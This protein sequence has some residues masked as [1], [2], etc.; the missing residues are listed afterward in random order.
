MKTSRGERIHIGIFGKTNSGKSSLLN[1]ITGQDMAVVS[2]EKGTTT[3]PVYKT[4]ELLPAG[5]VVFIDTAG[6]DDCGTVGDL[7]TEKTR[8]IL[9][10]V[11]F[12]LLVTD[13]QNGL[14]R[15]DEE[16][17]SALKSA[18]LP[19]L[20][21]YNKADI[22]SAP[23]KENGIYVS[24]KTGE[25]IHALKEKIAVTA[26]AE[27][28]TPL[29]ADLINAGDT[30]ILVIPIDKAAP[31][32][33]IILPQ[34]QVLREVLD[35]G[36]IGISTRETEL[37]KTLAALREPPALVITD[38]QA[39]KEVAAILPESIPL[40]SFSIL[41]SRRKGALKSAISG[42]YAL[43]KICDGD[44]I[45]ISEACSHHRQCDDIATVKLPRLI[46]AHTNAKPVYEF[47]SGGEFPND[48]QKYKLIIHC[49]AC[50]INRREMQFR[51]NEAEASKIPITNFGI[52]IGYMTG[53]LARNLETLSL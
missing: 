20:V 33:R 26:K 41:M 1:A 49:G 4:M 9:R 47:T 2:A 25:N 8:E 39:F 38:S 18:D 30:V 27:D 45:L 6:L 51:Q 19:Y 31:K 10:K 40:T 12:A 15:E 52:A 36:A 37:A 48:L 21:V 24:A 28:D 5:P 7:R 29:V 22:S 46:E 3:D 11:D 43:D 53:I 14:S 13:A 44:L 50:M 17:I 34:Q 42:V 35:C 32:G 16:L 23:R